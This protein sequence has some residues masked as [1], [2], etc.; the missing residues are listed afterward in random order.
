[1][2][3]GAKKTDSRL[4]TD[5]KLFLKGRGSSDGTKGEVSGLPTAPCGDTSDR[6]TGNESCS[7]ADDTIDDV[8]D[9]VAGF[10]TEGERWDGD[11]DGDGYGDIKTNLP[12]KGGRT[13][14]KG[15][16]RA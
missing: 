2:S 3:A 13:V 5:T 6:V 12:K 9:I 7:V 4:P 14:R 16:R 8:V 1:M 15:V 10:D 11:G